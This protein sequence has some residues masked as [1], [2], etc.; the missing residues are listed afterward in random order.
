MSIAIVTG[1]SS[2]LGR[3]FVI[4]ICKKYPE[5]GE[6]WIVARRKNR[7]EQ[8]K[9]NCRCKL[10]ILPF[11]LSNSEEF[12]EL[13][14]LLKKEKPK[15]QILMNGAGFGKYGEFADSTYE[16]NLSMVDV[17]C[18]SLTAITYLCIPYMKRGGHIVFM[19]SAAAFLPQPRFA[20]Y[21]ATKSYVLSFSRALRAELSHKKIYVMAICPGSVDTE[22]FNTSHKGKELASY[23]KVFMANPKKV[24]EAAITHMKMKK[25]ISVYGVPMKSFYILSKIVPHKLLIWI[26]DIL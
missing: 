1:A 22:F 19:A 2:G 5:L 6:I 11:D 15:I 23:K 10:R 21:A 26:V 3:E 24:V 20:I 9:E 7:L 12:L 17:N 16:D 18:K 4:Q 25:E 13:K 8:L 14:E